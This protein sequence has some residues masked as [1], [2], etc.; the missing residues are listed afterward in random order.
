MVHNVL[1][2]DFTPLSTE[3]PTASRDMTVYSALIWQTHFCQT[4]NHMYNRIISSPNAPTM[5][6]LLQMDAEIQEW[7]K[8]LPKWMSADTTPQV[9][10]EAP[11][12]YFAAH[13]LHWRYNNL[14]FLIGRRVFVERCL[15]GQSF[16]PTAQDNNSEEFALLDICFSCALDTIY[17]IHKFFN[18]RVLNRLECWYGL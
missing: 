18:G 9:C 14:R 2:R 15:R 8:T 3:V 7:Y 17:D 4:S 10:R 12:I 6:E 13:K 16:S 5:E 11:W 1:D